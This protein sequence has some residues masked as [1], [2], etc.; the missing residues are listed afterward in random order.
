MFKY[1]DM[2][3]EVQFDEEAIRKLKESSS[4]LMKEYI[5]KEQNWL[6]EWK[7]KC[8]KEKA[9]EGRIKAEQTAKRLRPSTIKRKYSHARF[10]A[11]KAMP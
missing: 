11:S 3:R 2:N 8:D 5:M 4:F 9:E 7:V 10:L 6:I 1:E